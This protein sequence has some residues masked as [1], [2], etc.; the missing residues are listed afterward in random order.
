[1]PAKPSISGGSY[2]DLADKAIYNEEERALI[3]KAQLAKLIRSEGLTPAEARKQ[4]KEH[5]K[6][7]DTSTTKAGED[8]MGLAEAEQEYTKEEEALDEVGKLDRMAEAQSREA[9]ARKA[10][11]AQSITQTPMQNRM[12]EMGATAPVSQGSVT[13]PG[14]QMQIPPTD[15]NMPAPRAMTLPPTDIQMPRQMTLDPVDINVAR[16]QHKQ[17]VAWIVSQRLAPA[18]ELQQI[19]QLDRQ[20]ASLHLQPQK[21]NTVYG[22]GL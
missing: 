16:E 21:T 5:D 22:G 8:V 13:Q 9:M 2:Q 6:A 18:T 1:M 17:A 4:L 20:Y 10:L 7:T 12:Y 11:T 14:S 19:Q 15:V 3:E